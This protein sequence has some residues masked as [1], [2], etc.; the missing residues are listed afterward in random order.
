MALGLLRRTSTMGTQRI[1]DGAIA[2]A[3]MYALSLQDAA[4]AMLA[5]DFRKA[6]H[7][8]AQSWLQVQEWASG[9]LCGNI[10]A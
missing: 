10:G 2:Q 4:P 1:P 5:N 8:I 7:V 6:I 9:R 3:D